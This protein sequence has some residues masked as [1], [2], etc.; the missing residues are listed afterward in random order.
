MKFRGFSRPRS[1]F[2]RLPNDWFEVWAWVR[3]V[4]GRARIVGLLKVVEYVIKWTW[5]HQNYDRPVRI[6]RRE[7]ERGRRWGRRRLDRGTGLTSTPLVSAIRLAERLGLLEVLDGDNGLSYLPR[8]RTDESPGDA[9]L[10]REG[11]EWQGFLPPKASY[12]LVPEVWTDLTAGITSETEILAVEYFFRHTWGWEGGWHEACWMTAEEVAEGRRYRSAERRGERYDGGIG[13]SVRAVRD[14]L[15]QAVEHG[16]LV[17]RRDRR[18]QIEYAL[19]LKG[20]VVSGEGEFLGFE[21]GEEESRPLTEE[22][23]PLGEESRPPAE[24]SRPLEEESRP[25]AEESRP[26]EEESRP[27]A[28]ESRPYINPDTFP[29]TLSDTTTRHPAAGGGGGDANTHLLR[30]LTSLNPPMSREDAVNLI[31]AY[32]PD[33]IQGWLKVLEN[34]PTVRSVPAL[35]IH[36]LRTGQTPPGGDRRRPAPECPLCG[37]TGVVRIAGPEGDPDRGRTVVC[38]RCWGK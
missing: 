33:L 22:S 18:G 9:F 24:E 13:Y 23:R 19:H 10:P 16:W 35:L 37:G 25:P 29:D 6:S 20:M 26:L 31:A 15:K 28:E 2:Y 34:D 7:F 17:W 30:R 27:P 5:G 4:S 14:A 1:N 8:L 32:G 36:K 21:G 11:G 3:R 12:F 38:P